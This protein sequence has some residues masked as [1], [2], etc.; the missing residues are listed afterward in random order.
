MGS[1]SEYQLIHK[2]GSGGSGTVY[3]ARHIATDRIVALKKFHKTEDQGRFKNEARIQ[4][5]LNHPH[6]AQLYDF[7]YDDQTPVIIMEYIEGVTLQTLIN[8]SKSLTTP[9]KEKIFIQI[10]EAVAYLHDKS[11]IH[12][13]L[14]PANVKIDSSGNVKLIDFGISK[15]LSSPQ[16]TKEG[17]LVGT[18][19]YS[20]PERLTGKNLPQSDIWSLGIILYELM[21]L[22]PFFKE[23][24]T[25]SQLSRL[26]DKNFIAEKIKSYDGP[27][28]L[29]IKKCLTYNPKLRYQNA[30]ELHKLMKPKKSKAIALKENITSDKRNIWIP[31]IVSILLLAWFLW[32]DLSTEPVDP[33]DFIEPREILFDLYPT[34]ATLIID[35]LDLDVLHNQSLTQEKGTILHATLQA[36]GF[37]TKHVV[38]DYNTHRKRQT[39]RY[40]LEK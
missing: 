21:T 14:K 4:A 38:I 37:L 25:A 10:L 1:T 36:E 9:V 7:I 6:I 26:K 31:A 11:I 30:T 18:I 34:D 24:N 27:H 29:V 5:N 12:R 32:P 40:Y 39:R 2:L 20:A 8:Q 13:D 19:N 28:A 22:K 17:H 23:I 15:G 33:Q 3:K 16:F 35:D